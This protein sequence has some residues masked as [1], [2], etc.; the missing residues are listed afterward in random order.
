M[1]SSPSRVDQVLEVLDW[2]RTGRARELREQSG[3][4]QQDIAEHCGVTHTAVTRWERGDR[5][6]SGSNAVTYHD[7]LSRLAARAA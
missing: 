1:N 6:P 4:T 3:L 7:V 5:R 2:I